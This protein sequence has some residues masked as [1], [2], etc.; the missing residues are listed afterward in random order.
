MA[1]PDDVLDFYGADLGPS[2]KVSL[3]I[4]SAASDQLPVG[5][6]L[7]QMIGNTTDRA[8]VKVGAY[9]AVTPISANADIP[10]TPMGAG[11]VVAFE[12]NVRPNFNDQIAGIMEANIAKL[13]LTP[14]S[15]QTVR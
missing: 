10:S 7:V 8:W 5:R 13:I 12:L 6:W 2:R 4:V 11:G 3:S 14:L 1:R 15:R 9:N